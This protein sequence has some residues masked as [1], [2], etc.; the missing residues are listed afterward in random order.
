MVKLDK[1]E[2]YLEI[3]SKKIP[4]N[5]YRHILSIKE[6]EK[7]ILDNGFI[8]NNDDVLIFLEKELMKKKSS[9]I[10]EPFII[11]YNFFREEF[12]F[13]R[14]FSKE[15]INFFIE[16]EEKIVN[17]QLENIIM[18]LDPKAFEHFICDFLNDIKQFYKMN[19]G[20]ITRDG[21]I[22]FNGYEKTE[23]GNIRI[24]GQVKRVKNKVPTSTIVNFIGAIQLKSKNK[25]CKGIIVSTGGFTKDALKIIEESPFKIE[26]IDLIKLKS[27]IIEYQKGIK[28]HHAELIII[29]EKY[30]EEIKLFTY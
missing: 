19:V 26:I 22:D 13:D 28:Q 30:W 8:K 18:T 10:I 5:N 11:N 25:K 6:F 1:F 7:F 16:W 23:N 9:W 15:K 14:I 4:F 12:I 20:K 3:F 21:G 29:D 2:N 27:M 17:K 24:F